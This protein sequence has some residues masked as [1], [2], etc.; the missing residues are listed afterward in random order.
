MVMAVMHGAH[1]AMLLLLMNMPTLVAL[2]IPHRNILFIRATSLSVVTVCTSYRRS[3]LP[4]EEEGRECK[5]E[6][7]Q[8]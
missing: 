1:R 6:A 3:C 8:R 4:G 2:S 5:C 7:T